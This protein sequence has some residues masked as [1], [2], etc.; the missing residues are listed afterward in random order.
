MILHLQ[1]QTGNRFSRS[2]RIYYD[3]PGERL[4]I[5]EE[6]S[7]GEE[8]TASYMEYFFFKEASDDSLIDLL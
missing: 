2:G 5:V 1:V 4:A 7:N 8:E 6:Y 3:A